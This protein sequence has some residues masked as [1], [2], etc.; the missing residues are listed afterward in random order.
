M[1]HQILSPKKVVAI[2]G[3][4]A[5]G[6][7]ALAVRLAKKFNGI[8]ISADS[9]QIYKGLDVATAK[10]T[11]AEMQNIPHYLLD[12]KK[13]TE[14]FDVATYQSLVYTLLKKNNYNKLPIIAGGTGLYV[15]SVTDG[16][17]FSDAKPDQKLRT[18][19]EKQP[20]SKLVAQLK[21]LRP[22]ADIDFKNPRRVIRAIEI[23]IQQGDKPNKTA[24]DFVTLKVGIKLSTDEQKNRIETRI[25]KMDFKKLADETKK[26]IKQ[27]ID[28]N[29]NPLTTWYYQYARDWLDQKLTKTELIEKLARA[30]WQYSRRQMTWFKKDPQIH[31]VESVAEAE[32]LV[33]KWLLS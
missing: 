17:V 12:I 27:E 23:A 7:S 2:V 4:T 31:W 10:I 6:K 20:L 18:R 25:K 16:Y 3:P 13:P 15:Q 26:L 5:S 9:R 33:K 11:K 28:F 19:L 1:A 8:V 22:N 30:D 29:S 14:D 32:K 21:K 24:P